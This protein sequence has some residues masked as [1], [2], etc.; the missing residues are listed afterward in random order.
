M[1]RP[2]KFRAC[3]T[4][5][6]KYYYNAEHTYDFMC[7]GEGCYSESFGTVLDDERFIVEQYTGLK[8]KNGRE[9]YEGDIIIIGKE[10]A[11]IVYDESKASFMGHFYVNY[12]GRVVEQNDFIFDFCHN[13]VEVI[14]NVHEIPELLEVRND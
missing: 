11:T 1:S 12:K 13:D 10:C 2:I 5:A 3:E 14:G 6:H 8:D 4:N 9:I 7:S